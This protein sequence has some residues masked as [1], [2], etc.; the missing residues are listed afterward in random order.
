M[1]L[2]KR[3]YEISLWSLQDSLITVLKPYGLE[4]KGQVQNGKLQD[5]ADGTQTFSF[6]IPMCYYKE[7]QKIENPIWDII[8]KHIL[9]ENMQKIKVIFNKDNKNCTVYEFL[10]IKV[11]EQ[12]NQNN[13]LYYK[14]DCEGLAFHELG[15]IGYK[16]NLSPDDFY[17]DDYNWSINGIWYDGYGNQHLEQPVATLNYWNAKVFSTI[18]NWKP[19]IQMN[20]N[21]YSLYQQNSPGVLNDYTKL[22]DVVTTISTRDTTKIYEDD[23]VDS[24]TNDEYGQLIPAHITTAR[25]K[26][27]VGINISES[28]IYNIT[29]TLAELFGVFCKYVYEYDGNFHITGR[30]VIYYNNFLNEQNG[31]TDINYKYSTDYIS[32]TI[33]STDLIT[34]L[35]VKSVENPNS[36]SGLTSIIDVPANQSQQDYILNFDYL[37]KIGGIND[38]QYASIQQYIKNIRN[39]NQK[40]TPLSSKI[41]SLQ[42]ELAQLK[43]QLT[44]YTNAIAK[45]NEEIYSATQL[46]MNITKDSGLLSVSSSRP[47]I[48]V[49]FKDTTKTYDS[50]YIKITQKGV[51]PNTI[52]LYKEYNYSETKLLNQ[53]TTGQIE[54]DQYGNVI[55][56]NNIY[57]E[58]DDPKTVYLTYDYKPSLYYERIENMWKTRLMQDTAKKLKIEQ[59]VIAISYSL[60][61]RN[62]PYDITKINMSKISDFNLIEQYN[63]LIQT[64][65]KLIKQFN[66]S[67]GPAIREGYWQPETYNDYGDKYTDLLSLSALTKNIQEYGQSGNTK[68]FWDTQP[69]DG[70][71]KLYYE[72][73]ADQ[74]KIAFPC[75]NLLNHPELIQFI[76]DNIDENVGYY[77]TPLSAESANPLANHVPMV[78]NAPT[79]LILVPQLY[80]L[81]NGIPTINNL[82]VHEYGDENHYDYTIYSG[83]LKQTVSTGSYKVGYTYYYWQIKKPDETYWRTVTSYEDT[84]DYSDLATRYKFFVVGDPQYPRA[85][86]LGDYT[87]N[88]SFTNNS[89]CPWE[90]RIMTTSE[91]NMEEWQFRLVMGN[92]K[93]INL[94]YNNEWSNGPYENVKPTTIHLLNNVITISPESVDANRFIG[95]NDNQ[96]TINFLL[97]F[98]DDIYSEYKYI[99]EY[100]Y[101]DD[102]YQRLT[103][104][105]SQQVFYSSFI[106][107][108]NL[109]TLTIHLSDTKQ[110][111]DVIKIRIKAYNITDI[112]LN[113][114]Y[115]TSDVSI[116]TIIEQG[117]SYYV[118]QNS[119]LSVILDRTNKEIFANVYFASLPSNFEYYNIRWYKYTNI[120]N[121]TLIGGSERIGVAQSDLYDQQT[122]L[123]KVSLHISNFNSILSN[124]LIN[125]W[126]GQYIFAEILDRSNNPLEQLPADYQSSMRVDVC[127]PVEIALDLAEAREC[128]YK[129]QPLQLSFTVQAFNADK[130]EWHINNEQWDNEIILQPGDN[131]NNYS[132]TSIYNYNSVVGSTLYLILPPNSDPNYYKYHNTTIYCKISNISD[133]YYSQEIRDS[134]KETQTCTLKLAGTVY[135]DGAENN[136]YLKKDLWFPKNNPNNYT[137][138]PINI[139]FRKF[140]ES[141]IVPTNIKITTKC[142][143]P[144]LISN[145]NIDIIPEYNANNY[146]QNNNNDDFN[147]Q[148]SNRTILVPEFNIKNDIENIQ[149]NNNTYIYPFILRTKILD[150]AYYIH[151]DGSAIFNVRSTINDRKYGYFFRVLIEYDYNN[152]HFNELV[153]ILGVIRQNIPEFNSEESRRQWTVGELPVREFSR[154][155]VQTDQYYVVPNTFP[156]PADFPSYRTKAAEN[157]GNVYRT[158]AYFNPSGNNY[159]R[160][161]TMAECEQWN[162]PW[163]LPVSIFDLNMSSVDT[164]KCKWDFVGVLAHDKIYTNSTYYFNKNAISGSKYFE[165]EDI[166]DNYD[167]NA[168]Q[169]FNKLTPEERQFWEDFRDGKDLT[170]SKYISSCAMP[171]IIGVIY[172][173]QNEPMSLVDGLHRSL[174]YIPQ[175]TWG[176]V[177]MKVFEWAKLTMPRD[178]QDGTWQLGDPCVRLSV[179]S[180]MYDA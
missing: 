84:G 165:V 147:I 144:V 102:N 122:N 32:R 90:I 89:E 117:K 47:Q 129:D 6:D 48:A 68:L 25:E 121:K 138:I 163:T 130:Y 170:I 171:G 142:S 12:H 37:H 154:A 135:L 26:A 137:E 149:N 8:E 105:Y 119:S 156:G 100:A 39:I 7:K 143:I 152:A 55:R 4:Y 140:A 50:Y 175:N 52:H 67:M 114:N 134:C 17:N 110:L 57:I 161:A 44:I 145:N 87:N 162:H 62:I 29:Q 65:N 88:I 27:R 73:G 60:Y 10:I 19:E 131:I 104:N 33:D 45:D 176:K 101:N 24:W 2:N 40:I 35:F 38:Q 30:K 173:V 172:L 78:N 92:N 126:D 160:P 28:N 136:K 59:D 71:Q 20:W 124:S 107:Q 14:V 76:K 120:N 75:I 166:L 43:A 46:L 42:S 133:I 23:F 93:G 125:E 64:K 178:K 86:L 157:W 109:A 116:I 148:T 174:Y 85:A 41:I 103:K 82:A 128:E 139:V 63:Y 168:T 80:N 95:Y 22:N 34:K 21:S 106:I 16:I 3:D 98:H 18:D 31:F 53:I 158:P 132:A 74:E 141:N 11:K 118:K 81:V 69:L 51:Y 167:N 179:F 36:E 151:T 112:I 127:L 155:I 169:E 99:L 1:Q 61:G 96:I 115:Y 113:N 77:F 15:K 56:I 66:L 54:F 91:E 164:S 97:D 180:D 146:T 123:F 5:N 111:M 153:Y 72:Y 83:I 159:A 49:L 79:T 70:E 13:N 94:D 9:I 108:D 177:N 150:Y 58:D